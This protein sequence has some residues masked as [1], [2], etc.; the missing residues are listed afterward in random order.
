MHPFLSYL[1]SRQFDITITQNEAGRVSV[2]AYRDNSA[3]T[4]GPWSVGVYGD[5]MDAAVDLLMGEIVTAALTL[6]RHEAERESGMVTWTLNPGEWVS[7]TDAD[8][9]CRV[10]RWVPESTATPA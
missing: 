5:S 2:S 7:E 9:H 3:Y 4:G 6:H 8:T 1:A 10:T